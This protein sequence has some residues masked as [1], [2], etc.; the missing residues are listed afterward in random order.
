MNFPYT[1]FSLTVGS[2]II[3]LVFALVLLYRAKVLYPEYFNSAYPYGFLGLKGGKPVF[4]SAD[5]F[6]RGIS[7]LV[8]H[9]KM[10]MI[11]LTSQFSENKSIRNLKVIT[12]LLLAIAVILLVLLVVQIST[13]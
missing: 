3:Y 6:K 12:R 2:I 8:G 9:W 5:F 1:L 11:L 4:L 7:M 13:M 10:V